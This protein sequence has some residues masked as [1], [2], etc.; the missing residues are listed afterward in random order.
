MK[1]LN[2]IRYYL[3][4]KNEGKQVV[5]NY[6]LDNNKITEQYWQQVAIRNRSDNWDYVVLFVIDPDNVGRIYNEV[7]EKI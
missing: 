3:S 2:E 5:E 7:G 6:F 4:G 1:T